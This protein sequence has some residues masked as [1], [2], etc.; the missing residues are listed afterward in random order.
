M[1]WSKVF[2]PFMHGVII[3]TIGCIAYASLQNRIMYIEE[4][5]KNQNNTIDRSQDKLHEHR[6]FFEISILKIYDKLHEHRDFFE[7]EISE[8]YDKIETHNEEL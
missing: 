6:E 2:I 8:I 4:K 3:G 7:I 5:I 1:D